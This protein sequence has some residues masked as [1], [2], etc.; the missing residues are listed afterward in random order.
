MLRALIGPTALILGGTLENFGYYV[1]NLITTS[2]NFSPMKTL[3][4][5]VA[6]RSSTGAGGLVGRLLSASSSHAFHEVARFGVFDWCDGGADL[7]CGALDERFWWQ[8]YRI[9][10]C[11]GVAFG[12]AVANDQP[13]GCSCS[14]TI[15]PDVL[16]SL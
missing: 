10:S 15:C 4:G 1:A 7:V 16:L 9:N 12:E 3:S 13:L 5:W 2:T 11:G 6:G 14:S 8:R